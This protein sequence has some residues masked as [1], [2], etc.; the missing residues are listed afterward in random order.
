MNVYQHLVN[1]SASR[2]NIISIKL[3]LLDCCAKYQGFRSS[4]KLSDGL[5]VAKKYLRNAAKRMD[6]H[7]VEWILEAEAFAAE[8]YSHKDFSIRYKN[9]EN[10]RKDLAR[11][12]LTKR[13]GNVEAR[14]YLT[15]MAY[16]I[17]SVFSYV[18]YTSN[19]IPNQE[20]EEFFCP[21]LFNK[22]FGLKLRNGCE[23]A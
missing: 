9:H 18:E 16:F 3:Y 20:Y 23:K 17:D 15:R 12:R 21:V 2:N 11:V 4:S 6:V 1:L 5:I 22:Y 10:I 13:L 19:G 7:D 14:T 8:F